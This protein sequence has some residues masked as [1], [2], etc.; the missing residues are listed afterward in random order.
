MNKISKKIVSLVT[1]AAFVLTL[2]P[3]AA[4]AAPVETTAT[5]DTKTVTVDENG[6]TTVNV[7][8]NIG[9][10]YANT[11]NGNFVLWV[12]DKAN[13]VAATY[14]TATQGVALDTVDTQP[15]ATGWDGAAWFTPTGAGQE[16]S[17]DVT[18]PNVKAGEKYTI[19]YG[20]NYGAG[21]TGTGDGKALATISEDLGAVATITIPQIANE[22]YSR[23][24]VLDG[25]QVQATEE[26][27]VDK[28][29]TTGFV[30]N[31]ADKKG[32]TDTL[33]KVLV[34]A[35]K[36][37]VVSSFAKFVGLTAVKGEPN[38]YEAGA[39]SN[40]TE[41]DVTFTEDGV[42]TLHAGVGDNLA[43]ARMHDL[44][45]TTTVTVS[46]ENV[47]VAELQVTAT[48]TNGKSDVLNFDENNSDKFELI[49][50]DP[51]FDYDG[52]DKVTL[53]GTA[54][55]ENGDP[56]EGKTITLTTN[57]DSV[58]EIDNNEVSDVTDNFGKFELTFAVKDKSNATLYLTCEDVSYSIY[59]I[60]AKTSAVNIDRTVTNGYV[61]AGTDKTYAR[62]VY[63]GTKD[64]YFTDA[65]QFSVTD[66]KGEPIT[67]DIEGCK[68][69]IRDKANDSKLVNHSTDNDD[70]LNK[71]KFV[72][73]AANGV[74]TLAYKADGSTSY[75]TDLTEGK[76]EVRVAL[77]SEDDATVTFNASEFGKVQDTVLDIHAHD[78]GKDPGNPNE[79]YLTVDDQVTLGQFVTVNAV[80]VDENGIKVDAPY[81]NYGFNGEAARDINVQDGTFV[82][83]VDSAVNDSLIGTEIEVVAYNTANKQLV[84][85]TLTVVKS[86]TD[87]TLEFGSEQGP[88]AKDNKVPVSVVDENGKVQQ[89]K[90][91][92]TAWV[93]DQSN[94]D[95]K[96]SVDTTNATVNSG[97]GSITVYSDEETTADI[98]VIVKAGT[99]VYP[100]TL[101]Y[102]FGAEDPLANRTVVMTIDSTEYVVNNNV[103]TGDAAP[104]IDDAWR[105]MV[106]IRALMEAFDAEVVWDEANPDVVTIN[107]DGDTQI[108]MTVGET[109]YT[110]DGAE[111]EMDTVPVNTGDRVYVPIRFVA[112]GIGFNVTPLYN[113]DGLTASVVF[114][115]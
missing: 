103:F 6:A 58:V 108:V 85:K 113:A 52:I 61:L 28:A 115:K 77:P 89:V 13:P 94:E 36:D 34:W 87:K 54:V 37:G 83:P 21:A 112:E 19:N 104:Y 64:V 78:Y 107:Y 33:E 96:V 14:K 72:W 79:A 110:I 86:Y 27:T 91:T 88:I 55:D 98:V 40:D 20:Y 97:K 67:G 45:G 82:T 105:T 24:G 106:P 26:T 8:V 29:I 35:E 73:D 102:T 65:V 15:T 5:L 39:V 42:Y 84:T 44:Q 57:K 53:K 69:E 63:D 47:E 74:Y 22:D 95:A 50:V 76:Y 81:V 92:I 100:A 38:V 70:P 51:N 114:Q 11:G 111:G 101:H 32:T 7:K 9:D 2:V 80:Y 109:G 3:V 62:G 56:V 4:F 10:D 17:V 93:A 60:S 71:I 30:V 23:Y 31:Y 25:S 12:G 59:L 49:D 66:Q 99:E 16:V 41:I 46:D 43:E 90:G 18:I 68:I 1:M 75:V 48:T